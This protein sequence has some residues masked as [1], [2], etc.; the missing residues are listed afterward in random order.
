MKNVAAMSGHRVIF[1]ILFFF[2]CA[3]GKGIP[4]GIGPVLNS[5]SLVLLVRPPLVANPA[6]PQRAEYKFVIA[7]QGENDYCGSLSRG[8]LA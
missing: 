7:M 5:Y 2:G 6:A 1:V 8:A 4:A 3:E